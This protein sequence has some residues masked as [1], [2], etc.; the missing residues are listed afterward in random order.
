[1]GCNAATAVLGVP[2]PEATPNFLRPLKPKTRADYAGQISR[3]FVATTT[4]ISKRK[5]T[6]RKFSA[7]EWLEVHWM[8]WSRSKG[9]L[10]MLM[11]CGAR[12]P[13]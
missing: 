5:I 11:H 12:K 3:C 9:P 7:L 13:T 2:S 8:K 10:Q 6:F 1:M 4:F